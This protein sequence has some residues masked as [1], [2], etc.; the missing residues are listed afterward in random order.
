MANRRLRVLICQQQKLA[1]CTPDCDTG[2]EKI[3]P[4]TPLFLSLSLLLSFNSVFLSL[5]LLLCLY[6]P[7]T[8]REGEQARGRERQPVNFYSSPKS[9]LAI[10]VRQG[11]QQLLVITGSP[12]LLLSVGERRDGREGGRGEN[13][14]QSQCLY[15]FIYFFTCDVEPHNVYQL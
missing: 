13:M 14:F 11:R 2:R 4:P 8:A 9:L 10:S 1:N 15:L 3:N 6:K 5:P 12:S 7:Q